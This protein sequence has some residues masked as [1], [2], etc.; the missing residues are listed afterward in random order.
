MGEPDGAG[1]VLVRGVSEDWSGNPGKSC[2]PWQIK[3]GVL[4]SYIYYPLPA[5][6][7]IKGF[8]RVSYE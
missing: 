2:P 3:N 5:F 6:S 7:K 8:L 1:Q 4:K